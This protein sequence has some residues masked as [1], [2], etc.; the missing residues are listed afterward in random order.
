MFYVYCV[1]TN[2]TLVLLVSL[3]NSY[4]I[5]FLASVLCI[6]LMNLTLGIRTKDLHSIVRSRRPV[7]VPI[8]CPHPKP[9]LPLAPQ[10]ES[11]KTAT[12][13]VLLIN[14]FFNMEKF[15]FACFTGPCDIGGYLVA[16]FAKYVKVNV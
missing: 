2:F 4:T 6:F 10:T 3:E 1:Y 12:V 16:S 11:A 7:V 15:A 5:D 14:C 13:F 9:W 8:E